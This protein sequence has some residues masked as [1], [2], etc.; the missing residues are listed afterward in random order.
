MQSR[1]DKPKVS[2]SIE[3]RQLTPAQLE[4]GKRLFKSLIAR[5]QSN[6]PVDRGKSS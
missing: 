1:V 2:F 3:R 4:A 5:A 6:I